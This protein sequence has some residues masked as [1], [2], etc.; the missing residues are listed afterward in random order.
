MR[1]AKVEIYNYKSIGEKCVI[2]FDEKS[3]ILVGKSNVGKTNILEAILFAFD[4]EPLKKE[5]I[6]SWSKD[7]PLSVRVFLKVEEEDIPQLETI[8][9]SFAKLKFIIVNKFVNGKVEYDAEPDIPVK[10]VHEPSDEVIKNLSNFRARIRSTVRKSSTLMNTLETDDPVKIGFSSLNAFVDTDKKLNPQQ[11]ENEQEAALNELLVLLKSVRKELKRKKY[12]NLDIRGIK[13]RL[14]YLV[15][16]VTDFVPHIKYHERVYGPLTEENLEDFLPYVLY[17]S[18]DDELDITEEIFVD[19]IRK[20]DSGNFMKGLIDI[21]KIDIGILE[22][23]DGREIADPL[24]EANDN[25]AMRLSRYWNQEKLKI[26]LRAD[27]DPKSS[28]RKV[29]LDF[30]GGE[31]RRSRIFDQS[32]GTKWFMAFVVEYLVNQSDEDATILLLDEPGIILHAGAQKDLLE[33]FEETDPRIQII[34]TTHSPYMIN[35]NF[36]LRIRCVEKGDGNGTIKGTYVNQKP[37]DSPKCRAWEPIRSSLGI[38][39]GDSLFVGGINLIVEGIT[40]QIILSS[41]IQVINKIEKK[42]KFDINKVSITFAGDN[43]NLVALAIFCNQE[44]QGMKVLLDGDR[45]AETRKK[46]IKAEIDK[47]QIFIINEIIGERTI[48]IENLFDPDFYHDCVLEAYQELVSLGICKGLP[49]N[50]ADVEGKFSDKG[51]NEKKK[52]GHSKFYE[53]YFKIN[54]KELGDFSKVLVSKKLA[55][56]IMSLGEDEQRKIIKPFE[57]LIK[58]IWQEEPSWV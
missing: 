18:V 28:K 22:R 41:V 35:K 42:T 20:A 10:K 6:C 27:I 13:M 30:I 31:G 58:K 48:D 49:K 45:G 33:R 26:V 11:N 56:K 44:T 19:G 4:N 8:D 50:W 14:S 34:Y 1:I 7:E 5:H 29:E 15:H 25:I 2:D 37:Y 40:D 3:T 24:R 9:T 51:N 36:P 16:D 21:S 52:W 12:S 39:L 32:P 47:D 38:L 55:D 53:E 54:E 17:I 43:R 46:L 57:K 23:G